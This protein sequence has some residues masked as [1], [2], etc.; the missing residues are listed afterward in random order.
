MAGSKMSP[1]PSPPKGEGGDKLR[2]PPDWPNL[3]ASQE[4]AVA[5]AFAMGNF[6]QLVRHVQPLLHAANL[7]DLRPSAG[8]PIAA[9]ELMKWATHTAKKNQFPETLLALGALRL[10]RQFDKADELIAK[11]RAGVPAEWQAAFANEEAALAWH[12]G[13]ADEAL[14]MWQSQP[15]S[16]PVHFNR[17]MAALFLGKPADA[18]TALQKAIEQLP[19]DS[20]WHHLGKLYLALAQRQA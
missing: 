13:R 17:G 19:E 3:V 10:A 5:L 9:P 15:D 14:K 7:G 2:A 11:L 1:P 16:I 12:R 20:A 6:P 8:R 4:P 18:L